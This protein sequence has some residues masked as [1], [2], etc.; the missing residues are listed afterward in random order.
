MSR[1]RASLVSPWSV[2]GAGT[3]T[4]LGELGAEQ[5]A[6]FQEAWCHVGGAVDGTPQGMLPHASFARVLEVLGCGQGASSRA[7]LPAAPPAL[8]V[9][10]AGKDVPFERGAAAWVALMSGYD[11]P[12]CGLCRSIAATRP[13]P[14]DKL[15]HECEHEQ[16]RCSVFCDA[17]G[18]EPVTTAGINS[19]IRAVV[20]F[21]RSNG[22][23][24]TDTESLAAACVT[25]LTRRGLDLTAGI[26]L[27]QAQEALENAL[28][29]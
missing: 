27:D 14:G 28:I 18:E 16:G 26:T 23:G 10:V 12:V 22:T 9:I 2:E 29:G 5:R 21:A 6:E 24:E 1:S 25:E 8:R 13:W 4:D 3:N 15:R 17:A 7:R 20:A 11:G 19:G